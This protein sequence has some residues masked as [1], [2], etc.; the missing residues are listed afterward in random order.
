MQPNLKAWI[1][2]NLLTEDPN[3]YTATVVVNG[4]ITMQDIVKELANEGMEVKTETA[5]DI[6][7]RFNRKTAELVLSG[8]NVNTGLVY[9]RPAIKGVF[10]GKTWD[11]AAHS[12]YVSIN[13]GADLREA[14]SETQVVIL[15]EQS[16][17]IEILSLTDTFTGKTDGSLTK[18][19]NAEI[20]G[21]YLKI[22]GD[23]VACGIT[24]RNT[25]TQAVTKL[26][27]SD[28]VLNEPS[29]LLIFLPAALEAGEY[30]LT[31]TTQ[32]S[33]GNKPIKEPRTVTFDTP[34]VIA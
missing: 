7:T 8:Y 18:G 19:R 22:D 10:Y 23:N 29:R 33:K 2:K 12:V 11:P 26:D 28:I 14:V 4:S 17:P 16:D 13:Q 25:A 34:V 5:I 24:F 30:E 15:G 20:K 31:I 6:L 27:A 3:D 9:M 32:F 21:S 1:R